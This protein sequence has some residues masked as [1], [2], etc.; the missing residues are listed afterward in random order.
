MVKSAATCR[1][2]KGIVAKMHRP[3]CRPID[4]GGHRRLLS[5]AAARPSQ[6]MPNR[7]TG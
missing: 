3:E 4:G 2:G 7:F 6:T 1:D 5:A